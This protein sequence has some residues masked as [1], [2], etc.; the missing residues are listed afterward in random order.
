MP[1]IVPA[2]AE[3]IDELHRAPLPRTSRVLAVIEDDEVL[4]VTG[5]YPQQGKL[6]LFAGVSDKARMEM[7]RHKRTLI[8]CARQIMDMA[9]EHGMPI[10]AY[11]DPEITGSEV[12]LLHLGFHPIG[13]GVWE[14]L[15]QALQ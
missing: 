8:K 7:N 9:S 4:G 13:Q 15:G 10:L 6:V 2:T 12:L 1:D 3:M 11:A 14:W 5:Y